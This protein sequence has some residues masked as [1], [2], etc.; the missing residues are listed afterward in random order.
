M[1]R[2]KSKQKKSVEENSDDTEG[3][4][5][6]AISDSEENDIPAEHVSDSLRKNSKSVEEP[7]IPSDVIRELFTLPVVLLLP[8]NKGS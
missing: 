4:S 7:F 6:E 8:P 1:F 5:V 3:N 2:R